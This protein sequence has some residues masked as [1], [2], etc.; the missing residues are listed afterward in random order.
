MELRAKR[1][2]IGYSP[3]IKLAYQGFADYQRH[4]TLMAI[5]CI[6]LSDVLR[7]KHFTVLAKCCRDIAPVVAAKDT[8]H[9]SKELRFGGG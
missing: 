2:Y 3:I 5:A 6:S 4:D 8:R 1:K 9:I 7:K